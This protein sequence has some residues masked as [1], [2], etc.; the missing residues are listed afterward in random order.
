MS[1]PIE[2]RPPAEPTSGEAGR[3]DLDR[4]FG[5]GVLWT[6]MV[7]WGLQLISWPTTIITAKLLSP[8]D[9][10]YI[11]MVAVVTRLV[12]LF[13]EA[14][15]GAAIVNGVSL[16][17]EQIE[18]LNSVS[19]GVGALGS[20]VVLLVAW[21]VSLFYHDAGLRAV[22]MVLGASIML[23]GLALVPAAQLRRRLDFKRLAFAEASRN[24]VDI[25]VTLIFALQGAR[26]WS[27][28]AGYLSGVLTWLVFVRVAAPTPFRTPVRSALTDVARYSRTMITRNVASFLSGSSD[29]IIGGRVLGAA[30][31]GV[32]TFGASIASAPAEKLSQLILRVAPAVLGRVR[33]DPAE[34]TR[35]F[36]NVTNL[37]VLASF[38]MFAGIA[39]VVGDLSTLFLG[40]RW[41]G[42]ADIVVVL[43][44]SSVIN[45]A[46]AVVP[47]VL[48]TTGDLRPLSRTALITMILQPALFIVMSLSFGTIG[49]ASVYA[50]VASFNG[51]VLTRAACRA[52][53]IPVRAY[54]EALQT[55][56]IGTAIMIV[57][58]LGLK[59]TI[60]SG[61]TPAT[62]LAGTIAAGIVV[63]S[64][65]AM[66]LDRTVV[67]RVG[68]VTKVVRGAD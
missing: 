36:L 63:Y 35:Y 23:E 45:E 8:A 19:V 29:A 38:P 11:A 7:K 37:L 66:A 27:L 42:L 41:N 10:G 31:L 57:V 15:L 6:G 17:D 52:L 61:V 51:V 46:C 43:C 16:R 1:G 65:A 68:A 67:R 54:L 39:L 40:N 26:Y 62:R 4:A 48:M 58:V 55:P 5:R 21:P 20:F 44:V 3:A 18:Q 24:V 50:V 64:L 28:V 33:E 59:A 53:S 47:H 9:Y 2:E 14:G 49:M 30:G 32:L 60:L 22:V 25:F 13:T 34:L 56:A 12:Q